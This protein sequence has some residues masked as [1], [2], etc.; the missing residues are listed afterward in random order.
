MSNVEKE[1]KSDIRMMTAGYYKMI[2]GWKKELSSALGAYR[3]AAAPVKDAVEKHEKAIEKCNVRPTEK[4]KLVCRLAKERLIEIAIRHNDAA[5]K[6]N[7]LIERIH[8]KYDEIV[9]ASLN[10]KGRGSMAALNRKM[11]FIRKTVAEIYEAEQI[12]A[13]IDL[14]VINE[15]TREIIARKRLE[16]E[17]SASRNKAWDA[18]DIQNAI[19]EGKIELGFHAKRCMIL[20]KRLSGFADAYKRAKER[21]DKNP[22][23]KREL[24]LSMAKSDYG[25]AL[26]EYNEAATRM[27][28]CID[29]VFD[30]YDC[31]K[32]VLS[33]KRRRAALRIATEESKYKTA[34]KAKIDKINNPI[35]ET[36]IPKIN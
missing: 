33:T 16:S 20:A 32:A 15:E 5:N 17:P 34:V 13:G 36:E 35:K 27:N 21:C 22:S 14:P 30:G 25:K 8:S 2:K 24:A 28:R 31:L 23:A 4:N 1:N 29:L 7:S 12:M 19:N 18:H 10:L 6:V 26:V 3:K 11:K 9:D